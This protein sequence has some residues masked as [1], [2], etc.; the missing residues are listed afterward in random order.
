MGVPV[1]GEGEASL[2][3]E[4]ITGITFCL[5][6]QDTLLKRRLLLAIHKVCG[7][8]ITTADMDGVVLMDGLPPQEAESTFEFL[9]V[10]TLEGT[11]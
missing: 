4:Q 2:T 8:G 6:F 9:E 1:S 3:L 5:I 11:P 10:D 7:I